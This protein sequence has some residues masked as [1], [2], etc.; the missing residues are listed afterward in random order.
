MSGGDGWAVVAS[1]LTHAQRLAALAEYVGM[2]SIKIR[3]EKPPLYGVTNLFRS[4]ND[5]RLRLLCNRNADTGRN[6]Q[7][8]LLSDKRR[9]SM[10]LL[11]V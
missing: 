2:V 8:P 10:T 3:V 6:V 7:S 4:G 5:L 1:S 11:V 9:K